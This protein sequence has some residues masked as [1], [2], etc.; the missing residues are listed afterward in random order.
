MALSRENPSDINRQSASGSKSVEQNPN[1][2]DQLE[3]LLSLL[4]DLQ[5][6]NPTNEHS[7]SSNDD[8]SLVCEQVTKSD[9]PDLPITLASQPSSSEQ[10]EENYPSQSISPELDF[11]S[12]DNLVTTIEALKNLLDQPDLGEQ[13]GSNISDKSSLLNPDLMSANLYVTTETWESSLNQPQSSDQIEEADVN[14]SITSQPE[15]ENQDNLSAT[16]KEPINL[17]HQSSDLVPEDLD[18]LSISSEINGKNSD[19]LSST[20]NV[21]NLDNLSEQSEEKSSSQ[22][23]LPVSDSESKD[24]AA[25]PMD[26]LRNL[27]L[28]PHLLDSKHI[29]ETV[30]QKL[31]ILEDKIYKPEELI[32]LILPLITDILTMK[33]TE[34]RQAVSD[35]LAPVIDEMILAKIQQ[36][37]GSM[38]SALAPALPDAVAEQVS[39]FPGEFAKALAPEMGI[40][41]KEQI[42]LERDS[43]VDALYPVIGSTIGKYMGE[44]IRSINEKIENTFSL[45]GINRKIRAKMQGVSEAE[46]IL[47]DARLFSVQAVFLIHKMSGLVIAEAQPS[48]SQRLESEMVAGMLTAIRSFVNDC[49]VQSGSISELDQ[50]DYGN[51]RIILE[52]AGYCYLAVVV[53]GETSQKFTLKLR[54]ALSTIIQKYGKPIEL[55][56]GDPA[57]IPEPVNALLE[58]LIFTNSKAKSNKPSGLLM[59]ILV[60][61][62]LIFIPWGIYQYRS[63]VERRIATETREALASDPELAVYQINVETDGENVNLSGRLPNQY[64]R[65]KAEQIA[66]SAAPKQKLNNQIIAIKVPADPVLSAAEVS[67]VAEFSITRDNRR[68]D[69]V[70]STTKVTAPVAKTKVAANW[71][72]R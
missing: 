37:K 8:T 58:E 35:S 67:R 24:D 31:A 4:L 7:H 68:K 44:E 18:I 49:I 25:D 20:I 53:Q 55:F 64:L 29:I 11:T 28:T 61:L 33:V 3:N 39:K 15:L 57:T 14:L 62:G 26:R 13:L 6:V 47:K 69:W 5:I 51:S 23:S 34:S 2:V 59:V 72:K 41:I 12:A 9:K 1:P 63:G 50:I 70:K 60:I 16:I 21:Q 45:E 46:L 71:R 65:S 54:Q 10:L 56:D 22:S 27:L 66:K 38:S 19:D 36:D 42:A 30:E 17:P 40:A 32:N 43:M 52:V 48:E